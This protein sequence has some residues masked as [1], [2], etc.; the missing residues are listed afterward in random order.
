MNR[1][2][3]DSR[4]THENPNWEGKKSSNGMHLWH[5]IISAIDI[6]IVHMC[7]LITKIVK[8]NF[9]RWLSLRV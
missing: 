5:E 3:P 1:D 2:A 8:I 6:N 4:Y 9:K 7:N